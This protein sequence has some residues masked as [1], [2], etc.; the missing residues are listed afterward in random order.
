MGR[1]PPLAYLAWVMVTRTLPR[2]LDAGH[3]QGQDLKADGET[4]AR[5]ILMVAPSW[6]YPPTWGFAMRVYQL[7]RHLSR[8]HR[9]TLLTYAGGN[10]SGEDIRPAAWYSAAEWVPL[11]RS[12]NGRGRRGAQAA[13]LLSTRSYHMGHLRS[14]AMARAVEK[15][16]AGGR[17]DLVQVESSQM[18]PALR[19]SDV[20]VVLDEHNVEFK[21]LGR[22]AAMESSAA[23][24]AF[25]RLESAK[26][27]REEARA[28]SR[29]DG[30]VFTSQTDLAVMRR[31]APERRGCVVPNAVDV[32]HFVP[33]SEDPDPDTVVFTGSIN[34]RPNTDAVEWFDAQVLPHLRRLRPAAR[35]VVV[36]Q[37]APEWLVRN[38]PAGVEFTGAVDDVRP[39]VAR[40]S[41]VVAPL[42]SGSGTRL[43][44]LEGLAMGKPVVTTGIGCEGIRV[45]DGEHV[46]VADEPQHFAEQV[47]RLMVD[48]GAAQDLGRRGRALVEGQYSWDVAGRR[49]E[50]FHTE[51]IGKETMV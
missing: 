27:R 12:V 40:A 20:P 51:L 47:A 17:F 25:G 24:R 29:A 50:Q 8:R 44:I 33:G 41:V 42:R 4:P 39:H 43:K 34:Y 45:V 13:S 21:L 10:R 19:D 32:D 1:R 28:W 6:P 23:R 49:L 15:A 37:G 18:S 16:L 9:V 35:F 22:L 38:A 36:G 46:C 11:P 14:D 26:A 3:A 7:A 2:A 31:M 30:V 48:R 5:S